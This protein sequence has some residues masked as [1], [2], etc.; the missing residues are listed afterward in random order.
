MNPPERTSPDI[1]SHLSEER[2]WQFVD[3]VLI[4]CLDAEIAQ[5]HIENRQNVDLTAL[6]IKQKIPQTGLDYQNTVLSQWGASVSKVIGTEVISDSVKRTQRSDLTQ[7]VQQYAY[8]QAVLSLSC[9]AAKELDAFL[10]D[11]PE[12]ATRIFNL[13]ENLEFDPQEVRKDTRRTCTPER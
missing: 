9:F 5:Q 11:T 13:V 12:D 6:D 10:T 1:D 4:D 2:A 3:R 8:R 7:S